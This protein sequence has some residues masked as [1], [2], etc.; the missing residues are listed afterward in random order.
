MALGA[1]KVAGRAVRALEA[2]AAR[3]NTLSSRF[4]LGEFPLHTDCA[5]DEHPPRYVLLATA[6]P[7][8]A[9]TLVYDTRDRHGPLADDGHA[10][11]RVAGR[12]ACHYSRLRE[13]RPAGSMLRYNPVTHTPLNGAA[14]AVETAIKACRT[15]ADRIDW[16]NTRL[17]VIDNWVC[18]HGRERVDAADGRGLHRLHVWTRP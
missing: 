5:D 3:P 16:T 1:T 7:R 2:D 4:G 8:T 11:F 18:L 10:L 17:A 14:T 6:L 9:A 12:R 13:R 15:S